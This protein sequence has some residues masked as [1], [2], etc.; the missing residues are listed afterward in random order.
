MREIVIVRT[1]QSTIHYASD[2]VIA[3]YTSTDIPS[4]TEV[5]LLVQKLYTDNIPTYWLVL[6]KFC[7]DGNN[8]HKPLENLKGFLS[9]ISAPTSKT[10]TQSSGGFL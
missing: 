8:K 7:L 2:V 9:I 1:L 5:K 3:E 4:R 6:F 10:K